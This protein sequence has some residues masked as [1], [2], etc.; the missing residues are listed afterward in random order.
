MGLFQ[1]VRQVAGICR[2]I[3]ALLPAL[4]GY[5]RQR[6]NPQSR[7]VLMLVISD[8]RVDPRVRSEAQALAGAGYDVLI[9]YPDT[10]SR[11][12]KQEIPDYGPGIRFMPLPRRFAFFR[13]YYP[14]VIGLDLAKA[15]AHL[16]PFVVHCH[17]AMTALSG[18]KVAHESG[19]HW[20]CDFHEW[21]SENIIWM[22]SENR[23][24]PNP[25]RVRMAYR[26]VERLAM[27]RASAVI[28]V[29][30]TIADELQRDHGTATSVPVTLIRNIPSPSIASNRPYPNLRDVLGLGEGDF[31][32]MYQGGV[33]PTRSLEPVIDAVPMCDPNVH[34][35]I[36]GPG[37]SMFRAEY[38]ARAARLG[39]SDR[40]H[41][42][43]PVPSDDVLAAS[44]GADCGIIALNDYC[45]NF[46]A[47]LP[48]KLFEYTFSGLPV[49]A[50]DYPEISRFLARHGVGWG[51]AMKKPASIAEAINRAARNPAQ[52]A[53]ARQRCAIVRT[54][55]DAT[56]E[57][58]KLVSLYA[59][60][61]GND[62]QQSG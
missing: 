35:V 15:V 26:A 37:M 13:M 16:R 47:A 25:P 44:K 34:L 32:A 19:A 48:N 38:E 36:R 40:V 7:L 27:R 18:M 51:F 6:V 30:E 5:R 3:G 21:A 9:A 41:C 57:W 58:T 28:T 23:E 42:L 52:L 29:S 39:V 11:E 53:E 60:L 62:A 4:A 24:V 12:D 14:F 33:G 17:D 50:P 59:S 8:L 1:R 55:L 54:E 22:Q 46:T 56:A 43:D 45:R 10:F 31:L 20:V 2:D 61:R 49:L